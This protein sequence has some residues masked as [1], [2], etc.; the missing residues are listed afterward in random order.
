MSKIPEDVE[1]Q[2]KLTSL[3]IDAWLHD[4]VLQWRWWLLIFLIVA[5][6][7]V[8]WKLVGKS[9]FHDISLYALLMLIIAMGINEYGAELIL[10]DYPVDIIPIFPPLS[11]I[12]LISLPL[13]YSI[14]YKLFKD[15]KSFIIWTLLVTAVIC[16]ILEP[17]LTL[18][19]LYQLIRG[20]Y[21]YNFLIYA[22]SA[23]FVRYLTN[24][25]RKE[26]KDY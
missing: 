12:N 3:H 24:K 13:V 22:P 7:F 26:E 6:L 16:F 17:L 15:R 1:I 5:F 20:K 18:T 8:W 21:Y 2:R 10:W 19:G 4:G 25:I 11:S 14:V 23:I 9:R